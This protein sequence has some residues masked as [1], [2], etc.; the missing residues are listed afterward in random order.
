MHAVKSECIESVVVCLNHACNPL[1]QNVDGDSA[2]TIAHNLEHEDKMHAISAYIEEAIKEWL[3]NFTAQAIIGSIKKFKKQHDHKEIIDTIKNN[4]FEHFKHLIDGHYPLEDAVIRV[5]KYSKKLEFINYL[6]G[7][8]KFDVN[9]A[10]KNKRTGLHISCRQGK[11]EFVS[12]L[13]QH[14]GIRK[15]DF[16]SKGYNPLM[17]SVLSKCIKTVYECTKYGCNPLPLNEANESCLTLA[18]KIQNE[19]ILKQI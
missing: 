16:D 3:R 17:Y 2:L 18:E 11:H 12:L 6:F 1:L 7:K 9:S 8:S 5:C 15:D 14:E 13:L 10:D 4:D 19:D